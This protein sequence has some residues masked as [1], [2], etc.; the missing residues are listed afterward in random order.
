[1]IVIAATPLVVTPR[2]LAGPAVLKA[3]L[4]QQGFDCTALDL[5]VDIFSKIA[6]HP[7][8]NKFEDFF[9]KQII[10]DSIVTEL[11]SMIVHCADR[12]VKLRPTLIGLSLFSNECQVFTAWLAAALRERLP[13]CPIVIGGP[14]VNN[15]T[16]YVAT[17]KTLGLI[18]DFIYGDGEIS[19]VEYVRGNRSYPGINSFEWTPVPDLNALPYPDY[20][21]YDF[22]WYPEPSVPLVDS[23]GCVRTC[24]FCDV[25]ETWKKFQY[26]TADAIFA[27]MLHQ[28]KQYRIH[29]FDFRS[30]I[31]NGNLKEFKKL[32]PMIAD[33]NRNRFRSEQISWEGSFIVRS[34]TEHPESL[35]AS[36]SQTN[37]TLFLGIESVIAT[38]RRDLGKSFA[39]EDI[40]WHLQMAQKYQVNVVLLLI[41]GYPTET[42]EDYEFSKQ[43]FR[44]R[45]HYANNTVSRVQLNMANIMP[46]TNLYR[47]A[48]EYGIVDLE[49]QVFWINQ[50]LN[51]SPEE[52]I[53]HHQDMQNVCVNECNFSLE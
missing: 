14:G 35:W 47:R 3:A 28:I 39:N 13:E 30:S 27:E 49:R 46:G 10:D 51:I 5:N 53:K 15:H 33:Y 31:S 9:F 44:D 11:S 25:I 2:A 48:H 22:Y 26:K 52:R 42:R 19:L 4:I 37:A 18:D 1:M 41:T 7:N 21:D 12:I 20:S 6:H 38:V 50:H 16:N 29:H 23:R 8:R 24:E 45:K 40:D 32:I 43:W 34:A 36:M 17:V